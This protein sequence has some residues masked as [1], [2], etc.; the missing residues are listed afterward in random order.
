MG[1][2]VQGHAAQAP[3][4]LGCSNFFSELHLVQRTY[5]AKIKKIWWYVFEKID[6]VETRFRPLYTPKNVQTTEKFRSQIEKRSQTAPHSAWSQSFM[7]QSNFWEFLVYVTLAWPRSWLWR[8]IHEAS[9]RPIKQKKDHWPITYRYGDT[10]I[11]SSYILDR[12]Y[13]LAL[14][15][16]EGS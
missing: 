10:C 15:N 1:T 8:S 16:F 4:N 13:I 5:G 11:W 3:V 7:V 12:P 2:K 9:S 6:F 14:Q